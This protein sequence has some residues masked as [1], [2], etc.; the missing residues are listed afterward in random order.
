MCNVLSPGSVLLSANGSL[1][2]KSCVR[3]EDVASF[4]APEVQHSH[5]NSTRTLAE[6]V[7]KLWLV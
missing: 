2:F 3:Y 1:A 5:A 6:K 4:M 7:R